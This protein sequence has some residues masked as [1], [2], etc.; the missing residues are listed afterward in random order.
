MS[1][2]RDCKDYRECIGKEWFD[3]SEIRW[4]IHQVIWLLQFKETLLDG[5]WPQDP[6]GADNNTSSRTVKTEASFVKPELVIAELEARL[7]RCGIQ[8][9]L[10]VTQVE[11]GRSLS[12]LSP[13]AR[14]VLMYVKGLKRKDTD[15]KKW[16]REV[17]YKPRIGGEMKASKKAQSRLKTRQT[18]YDSMVN[19][20]SIYEQE[21]FKQAYH[22]PGSMKK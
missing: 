22:R 4:C 3:F 20:K 8:A 7:D 12:N 10:L 2:C 9:E 16:L 5:R 11:D 13:G 14:E 21:A 18:D 17:Y 19:S 6:Y 15:F 1:D